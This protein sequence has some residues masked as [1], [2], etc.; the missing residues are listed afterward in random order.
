MAA[1]KNAIVESFPAYV[2]ED[3]EEYADFPIGDR[4]FYTDGA[5]TDFYKFPG[6]DKP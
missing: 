4:I 6:V 5:G 2:Q 3:E 1:L